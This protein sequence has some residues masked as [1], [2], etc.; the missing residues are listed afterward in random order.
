MERDQIELFA[1]PA[2]NLFEHEAEPIQLNQKQQE[3]SLKPAG[4]AEGTHQIYSVE[5]VSGLQRGTNEKR[6]FKPFIDFV[7]NQAGA[8]TYHLTFRPSMIG[9]GMDL[10]MSLAYA[11]GTALNDQEILTVQ[12]LCTNGLLSNALQPGDVCKPTSNT[13]ELL[14]YRN[15]RPP[16]L[17][18]LPNLEKISLWSVLASL[19]INTQSLASA[20]SLRSL[21]KHYI[22]QND[23]DKPKSMANE[24]RIQ[25]I[26]E[27]SLS[28]QERLFQRSIYRGQRI[29]IKVR[30]DQFNSP[31]NMYLF[32]S[33]LDYFLGTYA[34]FNTYTELVFEDISKWETIQWPPRLGTRCLL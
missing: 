30:G 3:I 4:T 26:M 15:L 17:S 23:A 18:A 11:P 29:H 31:G 14:T 34:S 22:L 7:G 19:S 6:V 9:Q 13:P 1:V 24:K 25:G 2:V 8:P 5:E 32:G 27:V 33:I 12:L 21:L 16:T 10:N 20:E 28:A